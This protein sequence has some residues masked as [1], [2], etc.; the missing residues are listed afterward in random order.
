MEVGSSGVDINLRYG[1]W[2]SLATPFSMVY[3]KIILE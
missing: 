3:I 2:E 1:Y